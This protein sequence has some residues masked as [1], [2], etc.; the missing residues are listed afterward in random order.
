MLLHGPP[1]SGKTHLARALAAEASAHLECVNGAECVGNAAA[2]ARL[3][4]AFD[5]ARRSAPAVLL[6]DEIDAVAPSRTMAG[7]SDVER[8][9]TALLLSLMDT[10]RQ[11]GAAVAVI[12]LTSRRDAVD[13]AMRRPGRLDSELTLGPPT[14]GEREEILR[15]A[16][17]RMARAP[18]VDLGAVA[19]KLQGYTPAD[20][21]GTVAEAA[22]IC[23]REAV[24]RWEEEHPGVE[25]ASASTSEDVLPSIQ[26]EQRHFDAA[27]ARLGP[28]SLRELSADVPR[29][30]SWDDLGGLDGIKQE[31]QEC[32]EW[33]LLHADRLAAM[34][35]PSASGALLFGPPGCGKTML[36]KS[37]AACCGANFISIRGPELL[38]KWLGESER[39]VR[40]VFTA[41]RA[42]APCVVF[43]D[44]IDSIAA[45]RPAAGAAAASAAAGEA[46]AGRVLNQMLCE[47]DG[48]AGRGGV[49]VLGASNRPAAIDPALLRPGRMGTLLH[50]PL[51]DAAARGRI[52]ERGLARCRLAPGVDLAALAAGECMDGM[53]GADVAEVARRAGMMLVRQ[54]IAVEEAG[55]VDCG[56]AG[57]S[58][59]LCLR[60]DQVMEAAS[61][62]RRSVTSAQA[63]YFAH[64]AELVQKGEEVEGD[65]SEG[66][67]TRREQLNTI[68]ELVND[69]YNKHVAALQARVAQLQ[70]ALVA[71]GLEVPPVDV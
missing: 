10:L 38:Q 4:R 48:M 46:A 18:D 69:A 53:S 36:A 5:A 41:A 52:L 33:P 50:V 43:I 6:I 67:Q 51:P 57:A 22:L 14:A 42:A 49:F 13:A 31:L 3:R 32:V 9:S 59:E 56:G 11:S 55:G 65:G 47:L 37:V 39:A 12:G 2:E 71:A 54:A 44:E 40:E 68:H 30:V 1:G 8:Q 29:D 64:A 24:Q 7:V 20:V 28:A 58:S 70:A 45:R 66:Q 35:L 60:V 16:A 62:V 25:L 21:A 34:G 17:G 63:T 23:V 19:A 15:C 26:V 61:S 27:V